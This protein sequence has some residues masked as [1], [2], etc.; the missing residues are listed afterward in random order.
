MFELL[1][2]RQDFA[3]LA[4]CVQGSAVTVAAVC[5]QYSCNSARNSCCCILYD[6][7]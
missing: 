2:G 7:C 4:N 3:N 1:V 6:F 5:T